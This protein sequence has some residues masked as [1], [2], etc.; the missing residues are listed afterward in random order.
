MRSLWEVGCL[1][2]EEKRTVDIMIVTVVRSPKKAV[3]VQLCHSFKN[4]LFSQLEV[5]VSRIKDCFIYKW[6][7]ENTLKQFS[8]QHL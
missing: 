5:A 3:F 2:A 7:K 6:C 1:L 8:K 4:I